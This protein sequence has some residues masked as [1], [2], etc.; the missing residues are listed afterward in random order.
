[1]ITSTPGPKLQVLTLFTDSSKTAGAL[2]FELVKF[3]SNIS[4]ELF[5]FLHN[6]SFVSLMP[7][8][9]GDTNN[10]QT[11]MALK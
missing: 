4:I 6:L 7:I 11:T 8:H 2:G 9:K 3:H 1:M 10:K 5:F